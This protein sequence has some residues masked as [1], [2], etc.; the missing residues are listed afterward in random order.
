M[1]AIAAGDDL[2]PGTDAIVPL[3]LAEPDGQGS[4]TAGRDRPGGTN[5]FCEDPF[6]RRTQQDVFSIKRMDDRVQPSDR[7]VD[8]IMVGHRPA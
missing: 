2:P 8:G 7:R 3:E 4:M 1:I 5:I 6:P